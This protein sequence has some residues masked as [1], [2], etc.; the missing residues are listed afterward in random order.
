MFPK[1]IL[2]DMMDFCGLEQGS[3]FWKFMEEMHTEGRN[4]EPDKH[5]VV[6]HPETVMQRWESLSDAEIELA[7]QSTRQHWEHIYT[8]LKRGDTH[9]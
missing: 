2:P 6:M 3:A 5:S 9:A 4:P 1:R 7:N 8:P